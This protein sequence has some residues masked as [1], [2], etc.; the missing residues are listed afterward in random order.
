M[1]VAAID[2]G[3][4]S[5]LLLI[6]E[7]GADGHVKA[8]FER[9]TITRLGEGVDRSRSLAPDA[10]AR[11]LA[12]LR[13]DAQVAGEFAVDGRV[14][15]ATSA[16]RDACGADAFLDAAGQVIGV[17]P[18]V[19]DGPT[20]ARLTH[21]GALAGLSLQ[22]PVGVFDVG[23][24]STEIVTEFG[25]RQDVEALSRDIGA[26]R[27]TERHIV[28]DPPSAQELEAIRA[29]VRLHLAR[30]PNSPGP[31]AWV[32]IGG[33]VTTLCA[34][35]LA[36]T[37]Y[38]G[39]RVH[40]YPLRASAVRDWVRKLSGMDVAARRALP[41]L[42]PARA[43]VIIAGAIIVEELLGWAGVQSLTVSDRGVRWGLALRWFGTR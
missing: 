19:I 35:E 1:R 36:M 11:T 16:V 38:D 15:V 29:D 20:E 17:R 37:R 8:L 41:G 21:A 33:T 12:C 4:N 10:I 39:A 5:V 32:G 22:G 23:G 14:A 13:R 42:E 2:I 28:S 7:R 26:V 9:S 30:V 27:M 31:V 3:T 24:G 40:G 43:D 25:D 18:D 6:A 34:M